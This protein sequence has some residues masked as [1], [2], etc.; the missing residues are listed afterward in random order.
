MDADL[1]NPPEELHHFIDKI[2]QGF[3]VVYAIPTERKEG[4]FLRAAYF[5]YYR[6][7]RRLST[8]AI[9]LDVGEFCVM[10]A[11]VVAAINSL[12]E[13]NR[14]VR[15][16][17]AGDYSGLQSSPSQGLDLAHFCSVD[18]KCYAANLHGVS[19]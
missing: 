1:Q 2:R 15:G 9:P 8:L 7:L 12:P 4:I 17:R 10:R 5:V 14:F 3:D 13:R 19:W 16:L 6:L 11:E 18:F